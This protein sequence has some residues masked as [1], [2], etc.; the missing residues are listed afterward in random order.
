[1]LQESCN[2]FSLVARKLVQD[3][4]FFLPRRLERKDDEPVKSVS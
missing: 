3:V 1:V 4:F 2:F